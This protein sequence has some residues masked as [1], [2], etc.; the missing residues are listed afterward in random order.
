M[1]TPVGPAAGGRDRSNRQVARKITR[2]EA[3]IPGPSQVR[4]IVEEENPESGRVEAHDF[5]RRVEKQIVHDPRV[6]NENPSRCRK[7][8]LAD[9]LHPLITLATGNATEECRFTAGFERN[10]IDRL[11]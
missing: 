9:L 4:S 11:P 10:D 2:R 6:Q 1:L 3:A 8:S 7:K 5:E